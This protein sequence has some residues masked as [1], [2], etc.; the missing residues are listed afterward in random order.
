MASLFPKFVLGPRRWVNCSCLELLSFYHSDYLGSVELVINNLSRLYGGMRGKAYQLART[1][2]L[3]GF[4]RNYTAFSS[5]FRFNGKEWDEETGNYYYGARYYDPKISVWLSVDPLAHEFPGW[6]PYN[7]TMNSPLNLVDPDGMAPGGPGDPCNEVTCD[8]VPDWEVTVVAPKAVE[9][10][11]SG[12]VSDEGAGCHYNQNRTTNKNANQL[13]AAKV[14]MAAIEAQSQLDWENG[15]RAEP[16]SIWYD[17]LLGKRTYEYWDLNS[18]GYIDGLTP[19]TGT[20]PLPSFAGSGPFRAVSGSRGLW[21]LTKNGASQIKTH[22]KF[23]TFYKSKS[24]GLWWAVDR[25]GHRSKFKV[26]KEGKKGLEWF[27]DADEYGNFIINKHKGATGMF[28][29]WG[30]LKTS[31]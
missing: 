12:L 1:A 6:S 25:A 15:Q 22:K 21:T 9:L 13:Q 31:K 16:R 28:I 14:I 23:G 3:G 26:F 8:Y 24:D 10:S 4:A 30:H 20:P 17:I 18:E 11:E 2:K 27:K 5:R 29:P 19:N 7:F